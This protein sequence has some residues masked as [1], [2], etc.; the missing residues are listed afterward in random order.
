M[1]IFGEF[2]KIIC[3]VD[4]RPVLR[5][6]QSGNEIKFCKGRSVLIGFSKTSNERVSFLQSE[7][8]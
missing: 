3:N 5:V 2:I 6:R 1:S 7:R 8:Y 4:N